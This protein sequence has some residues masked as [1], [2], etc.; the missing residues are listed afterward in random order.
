[1]FTEQDEHD[2]RRESGCTHQR[3]GQ[4]WGE[5]FETGNVAEESSGKG[6]QG[7]NQAPA[8]TVGRHGPEENPDERRVQANQVD[9]HDG[10]SP[11]RMFLGEWCDKELTAFC[12]GRIRETRFEGWT[13][14][15]T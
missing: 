1:M 12:H 6:G 4:D 13:P 8:V 5:G 9:E 7:F 10:P 3:V 15:K 14:A 11:R 2:E